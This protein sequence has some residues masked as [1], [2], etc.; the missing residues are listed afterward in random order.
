[1]FWR[2]V[3]LILISILVLMVS[4]SFVLSRYRTL[5]TQYHTLQQRYHAQIALM[6]TQQQKIDALHQLD[7]QHTEELNNANAELDKLHDAVRAGNKRLRVNAVCHTSKTVTPE[8][9]HDEAR[10]QLGEAARQDYFRL[11]AMIVENEKQTEY[12]QKYIKTQ[13]LGR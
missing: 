13:C 10:P 2:P 7:I 1:M 12:L 9:R 8:S 3:T 5:R 6:E 11:R 4:L